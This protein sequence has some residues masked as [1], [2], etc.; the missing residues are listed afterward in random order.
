MA[1][2]EKEK[3]QAS[4]TCGCCCSVD[5][6]AIASR[7]KEVMLD[8]KG[9]WSRVKAEQHTVKE[10]YLN[11]ILVMAALPVVCEFLRMT[12]FGQRLPIVGTFRWPFLGG[13]FSSIVSY[14]LTLLAILILA[15]I[16]ERLAPYFD[17]SI[18]QVDS[19][20]LVS[21][22]M[23]P[24]WAGG[25]LW[26]VPGLGLFSLGVIFLLLSLYS[27]YLFYQGFGEM[28]GVLQEKKL[29]FFATAAVCSVV[30]MLILGAVS[31][32]PVPDMPQTKGDPAKQIQ[33]PGNVKV[34]VDELNKSIM[35]FQKA[36]PTG[37]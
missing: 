36:I 20:K 24:L 33:L 25:V 15:L 14:V 30:A 22:S 10:L 19:V 29:T 35:H 31:G 26:L 16:I 32:R 37:K 12:L 21:Y 13:L 1:D 3:Q 28:T 5:Y 2:I 23:T 18:S 27:F 4:Q 11:Y 34:D 6:K 7:A 9:I 8:P 17:C